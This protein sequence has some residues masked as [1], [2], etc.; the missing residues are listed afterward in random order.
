MQDFGQPASSSGSRAAVPV[1]TEWIVM[2]TNP[3]SAIISPPIQPASCVQIAVIRVCLVT[4]RPSLSLYREFAYLTRS[5]YT[6]AT[7]LPWRRQAAAQ[8]AL[9]S[10]QPRRI[11]RSTTALRY[12]LDGKGGVQPHS[13]GFVLAF[14]RFGVMTGVSLL[15]RVPYH[16]PYS[17]PLCR[18]PW[19]HKDSVFA[20]HH[21]AF[22]DIAV[23]AQQT[24]HV[25]GVFVQSKG[26][27][28]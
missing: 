26:G 24:A 6:S 5:S 9:G 2:T 23:E 19:S 20:L 4:L 22:V 18:A 1:W 10:W 3:Q 27:L 15:P 16:S 11:T 25:G 13:R 12:L 14:W 17:T 7:L 21:T 28:M 8:D